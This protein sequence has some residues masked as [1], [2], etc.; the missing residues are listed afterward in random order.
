M[1]HVGEKC[2]L[3][4]IG[5]FGLLQSLPQ[6]LVEFFH[7]LLMADFIRNILK[8]AHESHNLAI[9]NQ[10]PLAGHNVPHFSMAH[11]F[12]VNAVGRFSRTQNTPL[13]TLEWLIILM[14]AH[15]FIS[16]A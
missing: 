11:A 3:G 10:R 7:L 4:L 8:T 1:T 6:L 16:L 5:T 13:I 2:R 9:F 14:P 12:A 15:I